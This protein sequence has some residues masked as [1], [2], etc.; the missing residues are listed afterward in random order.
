MTEAQRPPDMAG[1][2]ERVVQTLT[3]RQ[4]QMVLSG[5]IHGDFTMATVNA[6]RRKGL[7]HLVIDS[8]NGRCGFMRLTP[9]GERVRRALSPTAGGRGRE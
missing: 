5:C 7:F 8:P 2:V 4:R 3:P 9:L 1:V 6:L